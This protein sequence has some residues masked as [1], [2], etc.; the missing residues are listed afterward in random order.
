MKELTNIRC[1]SG[2]QLRFEHKST[3]LNCSMTFSV[4]LPPKADTD[5][6][7]VL[8]WLSG[9]TCTDENFVQKA[10]AQRY[11]SELGIALVA[12]DT[13]PRGDSVA[14]DESAAWDFGLGAGFYINATESPWKKHYQMYDYV[15]SE[16]PSLL[17]SLPVDTSRASISGHSMGGSWCINYSNEK[18]RFIS[19][20]ISLFSYLFSFKLSLG[21][22]SSEPLLRY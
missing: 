8:Y 1:F 14:D 18:Y 19:F 2:Q 17:T 12:P 22:E 3:V 7:P 4:Y 21:R 13:S 6:V 11:A 5:K 20:C 9:L 15:V 16:L 10:A